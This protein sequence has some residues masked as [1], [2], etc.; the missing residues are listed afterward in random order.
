[1]T[2]GFLPLFAREGETSAT[3]RFEDGHTMI[4]APEAR[5]Y[6][7]WAALRAASREHLQ[8]WEPAWQED[9]LSRDAFRRRL[10][11][12]AEDAREQTGFAFLTFAM[13]GETLVGGVTL[14]RIRRGVAMMG[15]IGYWCGQAHLRRGHTRTAV[16][17]AVGFAFGELGLHR[18]EAACLPENLPSRQLLLDMGF[19]Q[20]GRAREYL[21]IAG[22][23]RDHLLF[24][25][26][27]PA[28]AG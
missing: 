12:Y 15:S 3:R 11:R 26:V 18:I 2:R 21:R 23:W 5:D 25:L 6:G 8:P 28:D 22:A 20:E 7:A 13:P 9:E 10:R 4:R 24:G 16:R 27:R 19:E 1:M 17:L 14:S